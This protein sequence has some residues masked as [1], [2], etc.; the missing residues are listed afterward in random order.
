MAPVEEPE[1]TEPDDQDA[2]AG[3]NLTLPFDEGDEQRERK[4]YQQHGQ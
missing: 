2:R 1:D 4:N 3:L